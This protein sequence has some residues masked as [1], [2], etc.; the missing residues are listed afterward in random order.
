MNVSTCASWLKGFMYV[1]LHL[2]LPPEGPHQ[3]QNSRE[4]AKQVLHHF[5]MLPTVLLATVIQMCTWD[6]QLSTW[7]AKSPMKQER[8]S[9][10]KECL[11]SRWS[12]S[13]LPDLSCRCWLV[14][15]WF[16][17]AHIPWLRDTLWAKNSTSITLTL[18][19]PCEVGAVIICIFKDGEMGPQGWSSL[20][21]SCL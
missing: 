17:T 14:E 2:I 20:G 11:C 13:C 12:R 4:T 7:V 10:Y 8:N 9:S 18:T 15:C 6:L 21:F 1:T 3:L 16:V 5:C 19:K